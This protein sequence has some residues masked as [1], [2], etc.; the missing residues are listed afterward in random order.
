[1]EDGAFKTKLQEVLCLYGLMGEMPLLEYRIN[2]STFV[3]LGRHGFLLISLKL[4]ALM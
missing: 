1:M 3:G 2:L 4:A